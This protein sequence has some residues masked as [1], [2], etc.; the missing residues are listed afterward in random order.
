[1]PL[2][3]RH[4]GTL[5]EVGGHGPALGVY[6]DIDLPQFA[7]ELGPG[8]ALVMYTDGVTERNPRIDQELGLRPL[9]GAARRP[10]GRRD[11]RRAWRRPRSR[12]RPCATTPRSSSWQQRPRRAC[13]RARGSS[14]D[15]E[16]SYPAV[17]ES[18]PRA[19]R[20]VTRYAAA[21]PGI[22]EDLLERVRLALSEAVTNAVAHA[23]PGADGGFRVS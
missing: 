16:G 17:A 14:S 18:V 4:D 15:L 10:A 3:I 2:V 13:R 5:E 6:P 11:P 9:L 20:D 21:I 19:R 8:D 12:R 7:L 22:T 23:Y 1:M